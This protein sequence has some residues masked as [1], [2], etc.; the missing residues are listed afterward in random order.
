MK[1]HKGVI[2]FSLLCGIIYF[3]WSFFYSVPQGPYGAFLFVICVNV[4]V[5]SILWP[6]FEACL[7]ALPLAVRFLF[8]IFCAIVAFMDI[9]TNGFTLADVFNY[10][11]V[12]SATGYIL[13]RKRR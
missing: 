4:P 12:G 7:G 13:S 5:L 9:K 1:V 8:P 2:I 3:L 6:G 10:V 11:L